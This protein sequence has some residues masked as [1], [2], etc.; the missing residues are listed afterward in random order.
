MNRL[1]SLLRGL[2]F[3]DTILSIVAGSDA[4]SCRHAELVSVS[5]FWG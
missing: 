5:V 4:H 2:K 3:S 1:V